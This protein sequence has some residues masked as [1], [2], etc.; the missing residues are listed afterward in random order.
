MALIPCLHYIIIIDIDIGIVYNT[1]D[2]I[3]RYS[4]QY[5]RLVSVHLMTP[6]AE[7]GH[8]VP[9]EQELAAACSTGFGSLRMSDIS[10]QA[11]V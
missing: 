7:Q 6:F 1:P 10:G 11:Q 9:M 3:P 4:I 5:N 2:C 8:Q